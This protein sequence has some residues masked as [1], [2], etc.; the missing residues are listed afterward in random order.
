PALDNGLGKTPPM[1]WNDW[2]AFKCNLTAAL[3]EQ[4]ADTMVSSGMKAAGYNY[5][6]LD[7]C[8]LAKTRA[9]DGSLQADPTKFPGGIKAVA[10][11]VHARGLKLGIYE[12]VGTKTCAG[13]PGSYGHVQQDA[14]SFASWGVD[15]V[16]VDWCNVPFADFPGLTQQQVAKKLYTAY[17]AALLASGRQMFFSICEW[18]P[19]LKP[20]TWAPKISNMWRSNNDYSDSWN[21]VLHN[22]DGEANN[23]SFAGP[24]GWN[25]PDILQVGLGGM[26]QAEDQAHMSMWAVLAAPLLAGNDLRSMSAATKA[27]LTNKDVIAVDQDRLGVQ[28]RRIARRGDADVW[29]KPLANGDRAVLLVNRG[30]GDLTVQTTAAQ[31]GLPKAKSYRVRDL[32]THTTSQSGGTI[33]AGVPAHSAVLVRVSVKGASNPAMAPTSGLS[34][35]VPGLPGVGQPIVVPGTAGRLTSTFTNGGAAAVHDVRV[36]TDAPA[37]WTITPAAPATAKSVKPGA[38]L[39]SRW[40]VTPPST[41]DAGSYSLVA[42][43]TFTYGTNGK[44]VGHVQARLVATVPQTPPAGQSWLSD[45][46][47]L[48]AVNG[49]GPPVLDKNYQGKPLTIRGTVYPK[50]VWT[51]AAADLTYYVGGHCSLFTSDV[52]IDD[53]TA[54]KGSVDYQLIADGTKVYDS[55]TVTGSSPTATATADLT[56]VKVLQ[57]V[58]TDAGDGVSYDNADWGGAQLTCGS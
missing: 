48:S 56:G 21:A 34:L 36:T 7:D 1:G 58:V 28:G 26:T 57:L 20:W 45:L 42:D 53:I 14:D 27:I 4:T 10:N 51:N 17:S 41:A 2:Y 38:Q 55:G 43:V 29:S 54:G 52:G 50:G 35:A 16:K 15:F 37:G 33:V 9:A 18:D 32:W 22:L 46:P 23:G 25:D 47:W 12:D 11:Y 3:V 6:N 5:V 19:T 39:M 40:R 44:K 8:W 31:V 13:Y 24:G 49:Y 30:A